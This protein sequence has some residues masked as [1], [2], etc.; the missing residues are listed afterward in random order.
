MWRYFKS[1]FSSDYILLL[2]SKRLSDENIT[3][4]ASHIFFLSLSY[5]GTKT[6]V[7]YSGSY[8]KQ[9]KITYNHRKIVNIYIVCEIN[10]N[11]NATSSGPILENCLFGAVSL[12]KISDIEK[13]KYSA[14]GIGF[15]RSGSYS[16]PSGAA[17]RNVI[18][19]GVDMSS[20][21][22]T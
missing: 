3:P 4:P 7:R 8:L 11:D 1:F 10:K 9:D 22:K 2:K 21:K 20:S 12:T 19:F 18:I 5:L 17:E 6:R 14:Y 16:H 13:Y 15:D